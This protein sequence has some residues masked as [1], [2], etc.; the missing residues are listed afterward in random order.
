MQMILGENQ[1]A[2]RIVKSGANFCMPAPSRALPIIVSCL[3]SSFQTSS[4]IEYVFPSVLIDA[5]WF[6]TSVPFVGKALNS[7]KMINASG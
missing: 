2:A 3:P 4:P 1:G 6:T 5:P 7:I